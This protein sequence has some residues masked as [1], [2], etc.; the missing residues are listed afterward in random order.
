MKTMK[1]Q[2][3]LTAVMSV[4]VL[5]LT[6]GA[7]EA[8]QIRLMRA[9]IP[10]DFHVGN[11]KMPAGRYAIERT[12]T[13]GTLQLV[14]LN[15][16]KSIFV[17]VQEAQNAKNQQRALLEFR[18]YG[19]EHFLGQVRQWGDI[20]YEIRRSKRER[21]VAKKGDQHLAQNSEGGEI[22]TIEGQ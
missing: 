2:L 12:G 4:L 15:G 1:K 8:Q 17:A 22:V 16:K 14:N 6:V 3:L 10:F 7:S 9:N 20:R 5:M 19:R 18:R 11:I 21:E 13:N